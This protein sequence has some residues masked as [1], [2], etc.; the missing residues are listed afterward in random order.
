MSRMTLTK[1]DITE[2]SHSINRKR[3]TLYDK[4]VNQ[5][6]AKKKEQKK[7]GQKTKI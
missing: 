4:L 5:R 1:T 2:L 7:G 3:K 6:E